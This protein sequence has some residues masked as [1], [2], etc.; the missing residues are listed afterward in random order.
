[1]KTLT[2]VHVAERIGLLHWRMGL[3]ILLAEGAGWRLGAGDQAEGDERLGAS[4]SV[5]SL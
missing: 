5:S 3:I 2:P 1:V 4:E